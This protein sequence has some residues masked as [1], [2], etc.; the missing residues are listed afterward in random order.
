MRI[1]VSVLP[2]LRAGTVLVFFAVCAG[3]F[4]YFWV[5]A[6]GSI[7]L[8]TSAGYRVSL[9]MKDVD[10]VVPNSD[11]RS[12]GV[13]VGRV[14]KVDVDGGTAV[15]TLDLDRGSAPL[16]DGATVTVR[17]KTLVEESYLDVADGA[18]QEYDDGAILPPSAGR[19]SVQLDDV[20]TSLDQPTRDALGSS[21]RAAGLATDGSRD[22]IAAAVSGLGARGR[23]GGGALR[24]LADQ[25]QDL[26][27]VTG[28]TTKLLAALDTG[29]GRITDLVR[30]S[31]QLTTA[32]ADNRAD[33][34]AVMRELPG[35]LDTARQAS[36]SLN[37]LSG[38]L[39]PV[40]RNLNAAAPDLS[41][42]LQ[43]LPAT[44]SDL[45]GLIPSLDRTLDRAPATLDRVEPFT[46]AA[47]GIIPTLQVNLS[48]LNPTLGYLRPY[49]KDTALWFAGLSQSMGVSADGN[50]TALRAFVILNEKS[51]NQPLDSQFGPLEKYNPYPAA[52]QNADPRRSFDGPYPRVEEEQQPD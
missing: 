17:N 6:G 16:H 24:A 34:D 8:V 37:T 50:G 10:N 21:L 29:Q 36:G 41:A 42:A 18:G 12:A 4:G 1:P 20:L 49:G 44:S 31:G 39:A 30:D 38:S 46:G 11:V 7:P 2:F 26:K 35:V 13:K 43:E 45:R 22:D 27:S 28:H 15:V 32:V 9:A 5:N 19:K 40:A 48:D 47:R 33:L 14:E 3:I 51:A 25:S 52:G 23:E